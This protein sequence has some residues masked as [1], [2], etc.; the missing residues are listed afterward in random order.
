MRIIFAIFVFIVSY[1]VVFGEYDLDHL[2]Q[3]LEEKVNQLKQESQQLPEATEVDID[4]KLKHHKRFLATNNKSKEK[5]NTND[6]SKEKTNTN[7]KSKGEKK[8]N[9]NSLNHPK[10]SFEHLNKIRILNCT[11]EGLANKIQL[12]KTNKEVIKRYNEE[13]KKMETLCGKKRNDYMK[14]CFKELKS[15][16]FD[17]DKCEDY[18][19]VADQFCK[20]QRSNLIYNR[21][22]ETLSNISDYYS[23]KNKLI[24]KCQNHLQ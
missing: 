4:K 18:L 3:E 7:D 5:T 20:R 21:Q 13:L 23:K 19:E 8:I 6:K 9:T 16:I 1:Q 22:N 14:K 2:K 12:I 24:E 15:V 10:D 11:I 17:L